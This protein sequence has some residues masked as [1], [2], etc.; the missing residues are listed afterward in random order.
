M[1]YS[2]ITPMYNSF[3]LMDRF[4]ISLERQTFKNFEV[5]I[6]DD[7]STDDSYKKLCEYS[8]NTPLVLSIYKTNNNG[9]PGQARNIGMKKAIGEWITFIDNDDW[10]EENMLEIVDQVIQTYDVNSIIYDFFIATDKNKVISKSMYKGDE[11]IVSLSECITN[12]RNHTIGKFYKREICIKND[13][14][15]PQLKRCED[16]AFVCRALDACG[17]AYYINK[18][19][20]YYYQRSCS[21]SNNKDLDEADMIKAFSILE[22]SLGAKY[23]IELAEKSVFDLLYG[24]LL[25]MCKSK[26]N[27]KDIKKYIE[28]YEAKYPNWKSFKSVKKIGKAKGVFLICAK[29]RLVHIMKF[30]TYIHGKIIE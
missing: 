20:Y 11:G 19:L 13:I 1:K 9:G 23:P 8:K 17:S 2:I 5:I 10:I 6:I 25:M 4:F 30:I 12:V 21:L 15:F 26:K 24:V 7:C 16:V 14:F 3:D 22:Q 28:N 29:Y 27:K 18:P